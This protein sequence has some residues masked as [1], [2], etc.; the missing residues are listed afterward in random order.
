MTTEQAFA[1]NGDRYFLVHKLGR[2]YVQ[3]A[4]WTGRKPVA[5]VDTDYEGLTAIRA[6]AGSERIEAR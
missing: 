5:V 6:D 4:T 3:K 2:V 1:C